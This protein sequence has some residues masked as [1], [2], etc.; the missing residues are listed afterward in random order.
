MVEGASWSSH[1]GRLRRGVGGGVEELAARPSGEQG[2]TELAARLQRLGTRGR[3][4]RRQMGSH[5]GDE[6]GAPRNTLDP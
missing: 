1:P 5:G 6:S 4:L 2:P 3:S